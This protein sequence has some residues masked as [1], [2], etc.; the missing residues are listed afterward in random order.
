MRPQTPTLLGPP[1]RCRDSD[2]AQ[3]SRQAFSRHC[4]NLIEDLNKIMKKIIVSLVGLITIVSL[5]S[6]PARA[7]TQ[8]K[9]NAQEAQ[10]QRL[11]DIHFSIWNDTN[12]SARLAKF[13][14]VYAPDFT[15][16]DYAGIAKGYV[17][18]NQLIER[19]HTQHPGFRFT[20][21]P[22]SW[23]H[24]F[25]R[26]TWGFGPRETPNAVRGED[27]ITVKNGRVESFRVFL[28]H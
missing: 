28:D 19:V 7:T 20:P 9:R 5:W 13:S 14:E 11:M 2:E 27:I 12:Q 24:G 4:L 25:G 8:S 18:V 26:V 23:N 10:V 15:V 22:V 1:G 3:L 21:D 16:A 6:L 17:A